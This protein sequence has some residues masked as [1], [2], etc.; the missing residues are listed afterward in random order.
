MRDKL[1]KAIGD[2]SMLENGDKILVALSGGADSV[3]LLHALNS[4]KEE[5]KLTLY[6]CHINHMIRGEEALRDESF[7]KALCDELDIELFVEKIDVPALAAESKISLELCGRQVRYEFFSSL[8]QKLCAKVATAHTSSDNVETVMYNIARGTALSGLSGIKPVRDYIIR[9]LIYCTR[10]EIE[11]YCDENSLSYV[12]DSTNLTDIYTRNNIRH[13]VVPVLKE[14]NP[15]LCDS[16]S[17]MSSSVREVKE[18]LDKISFEEINKAKTDYGYSCEKLLSLD[19]AVLKNAVCIIAKENGAELTFR[20]VE[21]I[22]QAMKNGG[23]VDLN[24]NKRA[25]CKQG[26][27]RIAESDCEEAFFEMPF[28]ESGCAQYISEEELKNIHK[29]LLTDCIRCD[30][31]TDSTV[32]RNKK[33][34]DTFTFYGRDVTKSLKKLFNELKIPAEKRSTLKLVANDSTVLWIEGIGTSKQGRATK[35]ENGAYMITGVKND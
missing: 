4:V 21:L 19:N 11:S 18:Y 6:A 1:L 23:C 32:I 31:I 15:E 34:G 14:I 16:V 2:F 3:A 27:F 35:C 33:E 22:L 13:N 12:T 20:H 26:V 5:R 28:L 10:E 7:V 17:R 24:F 30:I 25:V 8:S 29:N 9:P